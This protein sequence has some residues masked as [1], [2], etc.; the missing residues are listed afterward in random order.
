MGRYESAKFLVKRV[1]RKSH[2]CKMCEKQIAPKEQYYS[3]TLGLINKGPSIRFYSYCLNCGPKSGL[4]IQQHDI[5]TEGSA[6]K[7][8]PQ[9]VGQ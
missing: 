5:E 4:R 7:K 2:V 1:A 9:F 3:E 8:T 6:D